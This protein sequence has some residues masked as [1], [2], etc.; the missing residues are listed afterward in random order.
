VKVVIALGG[1]ALLARE[2]DA[3]A[4][5]LLTDVDAVYRNWNTPDASP[6]RATTARELLRQRF[7]PGSMGPK[8]EAACRFVEATGGLAGIGRL[9][10]A[11]EVL[12]GRR[13][14][15][16]RAVPQVAVSSATD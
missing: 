4:L 9:E 1:N 15:I 11:L 16:V 7:A 14:T 8:V 13:G 3:G 6:L 5:L 2:L 12:E 10:D